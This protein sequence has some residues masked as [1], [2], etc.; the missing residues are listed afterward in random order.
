MAAPRWPPFPEGLSYDFRAPPDA[1]FVAHKPHLFQLLTNLPAPLDAPWP[2]QS[3][4]ALTSAVKISPERIRRNRNR[5][6]EVATVYCQPATS[7]DDTGERPGR[8][9]ARRVDRPLV[10]Q[11]AVV[12]DA[13]PAGD[14]MQ[15]TAK[16]A[17]AF[18]CVVSTDGGLARGR[19]GQRWDDTTPTTT[20]TTTA[21]TATPPPPSPHTHRPLHSRRT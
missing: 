9:F 21:T 10:G 19:A 18:L 3:H 2:F 12:F 4:L 5:I 17:G 15:L 16:E 14:F 13:P 7:L 6:R 20:T 8:S 1:A 11:K